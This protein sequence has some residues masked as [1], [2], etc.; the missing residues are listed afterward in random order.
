MTQTDLP[1]RGKVD[2]RHLTGR[3]GWPSPRAPGVSVRVMA[4]A[5]HRE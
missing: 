4:G 1:Q 2:S 5:V 3:V